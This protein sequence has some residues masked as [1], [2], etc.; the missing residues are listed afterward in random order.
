MQAAF[1][2]CSSFPPTQR[3]VGTSISRDVDSDSLSEWLPFVK[4]SRNLWASEQATFTPRRR[5]NTRQRERPKRV[6]V[7]NDELGS[8]PALAAIDFEDFVWMM[9]VP[10]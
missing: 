4:S 10:W 9:A 5:Y 1:R 8:K 2:Q 3:R 7:P 6:V